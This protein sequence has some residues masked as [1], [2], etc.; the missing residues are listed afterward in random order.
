MLSIDF[1][2]I[3]DSTLTRQ[4]C[5]VYGLSE[6]NYSN[7][8][9]TV[10]FA[11]VDEDRFNDVFIT[12][13]DSFSTEENNDS[14]EYKPLTLMAGFSYWDSDSMKPFGIMGDDAHDV[15]LELVESSPRIAM[16]HQA[17]VKAMEEHLDQKQILYKRIESGIYQINFISKDDLAILLDNFDVI[18][19]IQ[20]LYT[21]RVLLIL[22][23]IW[24]G[25][26]MQL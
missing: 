3:A 13:I 8:N 12:Q 14:T 4:Y 19:R 18:Q 16:K 5:Q 22:L 21:T 17:I 6:L 10:L 2:K 7:M 26:Q 11:I 25:C 24:K 1:L 20:S 23:V 9:Q 15:L